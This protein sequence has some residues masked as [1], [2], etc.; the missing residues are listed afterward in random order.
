MEYLLQYIDPCIVIEHVTELWFSDKVSLFLHH[1]KSVVIIKHKFMYHR[2][3][4]N[5]LCVRYFLSNFFLS[6]FCQFFYIVFTLFFS[7]GVH[8]VVF[9]ARFTFNWRTLK[10]SIAHSAFEYL[11]PIPISLRFDLFSSKQTRACCSFIHSSVRIFIIK[12]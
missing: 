3:S 2:I 8:V 12:S 4:H 1:L 6:I 7:F 10:I 9:T 5:F 11:L